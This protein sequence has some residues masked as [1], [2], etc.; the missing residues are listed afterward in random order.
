M[1]VQASS[2]AGLLTQHEYSSV[3]LEGDQVVLES[4]TTKTVLPF[5]Q[6]SGRVT[7]DKGLC[8]S[9]ITF[10]GNAYQDRLEAWKVIGLPHHQA[11]KFAKYWVEEYE[12]W[13]QFQCRKLS[14]YMPKWHSQLQALISSPYYLRSHELNQWRAT[15]VQDLQEIGYDFDEVSKRMPHA[16]QGLHKWLF[17]SQSQY[18]RNQQ[19]L[20]LEKENWQM[21]FS[22]IE[23]SPLNATQQT[24]VLLNED[25]NL[26][27][28]GAGSGKT[29]VITAKI[30]YLLQSHQAQPEDILVLTFGRDACNEMQERIE[31][32]IG[33][34]AD[35]VRINTFH[36]LAIMIIQQVEGPPPTLSP[37]SIDNKAKQAWCSQ[38]LKEH[39]ANPESFRRWQKHL[40]QWPIAFLS[41]DSELINQAENPRLIA[42]LEEQISGLGAENLSKKNIQQQLVN[43]SDYS[44]LNSELQL[45]WPCFDAWKKYLKQHQQYDFDGLIIKATHYLEKEKFTPQWKTV[46]VDEFQDISPMRQ[47][48]LMAI[49]HSQAKPSLFAVGDDWQSI[50]QF[51]GSS[52]Q[53]TTDFETHFKPAKVHYLDRT[54][55]YNDKIALV[56]EQFILQNS[57]Q[58]PKQLVA[59]RSSNSASVMVMAQDK[60]FEELK[61]L[62]DKQNQT[63]HVLVLGRN[64]R[65][66]PEQMQQW[67]AQ[68]SKLELEYTTCHSAKGREADFVAIVGV[69]EHDFPAKVRTHHL[70]QSLRTKEEPIE[71]AEERRLFYTALTRAK[72]FVYVCYDAAPS[73]FC[74]ELL[75]QSQWV[76]K[77]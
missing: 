39:W 20:Q 12:K 51:S 32:R 10:W 67:Q 42:W 19:W 30:A 71:F 62:N 48:L 60:L 40:N 34:A 46:L 59:N 69:N 2:I 44:R 47:R 50:Y 70:I 21:F 22:L 25:H 75:E 27:L 8:W 49:C 36:Q 38:W 73:P 52:L 16:S 15:I 6:L 11:T 17:D 37:V 63:K 61:Q 66:Q 45:C 74:Q 26:I 68:L 7:V 9:S 55:R 77:G 31:H 35:G 58:I 43:D 4:L 57:Q 65:H 5:S 13:H 18:E 29:S 23:S 3:I 64:H 41:G 28:A 1:H 53:I 33:S 14:L 54:Y 56:A 24:A 76:K 72:D